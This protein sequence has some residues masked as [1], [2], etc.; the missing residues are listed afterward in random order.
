MHLLL[1]DRCA[2]KGIGVGISSDLI[3][4]SKKKVN[5]FIS[6]GLLWFSAKLDS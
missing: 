2:G 6:I 4:C 3:L 1:F 5:F